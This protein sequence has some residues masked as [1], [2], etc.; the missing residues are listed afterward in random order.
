MIG[1]KR[2]RQASWI[3]C[4]G[5]KPALAF[6]L[7]REVHH[8]DAVLLDDADQQN[9]ADEGDH[10]ELG[11]EHLQRQ[12]RAEAGR[13]Q[14]RDDGERM[15][16]ALVEHAEHDIDRD[17]RRQQQQR[18][19][20]QRPLEGL[21][22]AGEVGV[23]GVGDV[24]AG[25]RLLDLGGRRLQRHVG[26]DVVGDGDRGE[27]ALMVD[28]QRRDAA[29]EPGDRRQR[30][31]RIAV[32]R[33]VEVGEIGRVALV[34]VVDLQDHAV[35][36]ALAVDGGNLPLRERVVERVVD[37]L[38]AHA[39]ARRHVAVDLDIGLQPALFAVGGDVDDAGQVLHLVH[40]LRHPGLQ[41]RRCP[42]STA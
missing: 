13:R 16:Q 6:A 41:L 9:D 20:A 30:H 31:L 42:G 25:D 11:A 26:R 22:V 29:G 38:D 12:Q 1:R 17:Q 23:D 7:E 36:V 10:R 40:D 8:H 27:L 4:A 19:R 14:R 35:L 18:L 15:R 33:H 21:D 34:F 28:H 39:E 37:V 2:A 24:H 5:D 32:A 3:A